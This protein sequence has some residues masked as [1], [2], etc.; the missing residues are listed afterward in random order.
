MAGGVSL[1]IAVPLTR[2]DDVTVVVVAFQRPDALRRALARLEDA[3]DV[4]VLVVNVSADPAVAAVAADATEARVVT[5]LDVD[6]HGYAAAVNRA[7]GLVATEHVVFA[8][9]DLLI[10]ADSLDQLVAIVRSGRADVAVPRLVDGTGTD[11]GT[12]RALPTLGRLALEWALLPDRPLRAG[13]PGRRTRVQK[14]RR[15]HVTEQVP[16]ATA[17]LVAT[18]TELL[19]T[20]PLPEDYFLYWEEL[21]WAWRLRDAGATIVLVPGATAAHVGGRDDVRA[22][23]ERLLARNAVRCVRRTQGRGAAWAAYPIVVLWRL[24]LLASDVLRGSRGRL[25]ARIAGLGA[26]ITSLRE[27]A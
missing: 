15:P 1:V 16:A 19:R 10:T 22:E 18:R 21:E 27:I 6:N 13:R 7:A 17:A 2:I 20:V 3:P 4:P 8:N 9:D 24:R 14:W 23:K 26:A 5:V 11:E 12:V 25:G